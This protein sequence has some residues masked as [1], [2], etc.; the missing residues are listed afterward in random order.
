MGVELRCWIK[1]WRR[2]GGGGRG[3]GEGGETGGRRQEAGDRRQKTEDMG[4]RER[5]VSN[6]GTTLV[7]QYNITYI[8]CN[9]YNM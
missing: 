2:C 4:L 1:R 6:V 3:E 8:R 9:H 7:V 5:S